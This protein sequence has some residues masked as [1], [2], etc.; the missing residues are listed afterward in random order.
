MAAVEPARADSTDGQ[1]PSAS[2]AIRLRYLFS[3]TGYSVS[4]RFMTPA[5][6]FYDPVRH[7]I[8]VADTGN[9]QI[10]IFDSKGMPEAAYPHYLVDPA[11]GDHHPA[12]PRSIV[13]RKNGDIY[14]ADNLC[15]YVDILDF[16]GRPVEKIWPGDLLGL[17]KDSVKARC[18]A[19]DANEDIYIS[20]TGAVTAI[21]V[22]SPDL[23]LKLVI[24][25]QTDVGAM[26]EITGLWVDAQGLIYATY[27]QNTCV[28]IWSPDGTLH[29]S[30]GEHDAGPNN[31]SLPD[32]L[33]TDVDNHIWIVDTLRSVVTIFKQDPKTQPAYIDMI[34]G[35]G[36]GPGE[37]AF[38]S[39]IAG[40][41]V[42]KVFVLEKTGA[43][44]QAFEYERK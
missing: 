4:Q 16:Q 10:D 25:K 38:P 11:T 42:T 15:S 23:K 41:G 28:R 34:G 14:V 12:Q 26:N 43:R 3:V 20:V 29:T 35:F 6:V 2:T 30:F 19:I 1:G 5:G 9:G 17:P 31:F 44:L 37:M 40:D 33:V 18:L 7:E 13:V 36:D 27:L 32:G 39:A 24:D 22:L 8:Y 21:L